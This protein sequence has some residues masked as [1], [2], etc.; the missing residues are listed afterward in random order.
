M[1]MALD[2]VSLAEISDRL[3]LS[4]VSWDAY[5]ALLDDVEKSG[6]HYRLTYD[7]GQLEIALPTEIHAIVTRFIRAILEA[8]LEEKN[9]DFVPLGDTT[10]KRRSLERGLEAD[11]C[12]YIQNAPRIG[13]RT[14]LD[15]D[16]DPPPD[17]AIEI[18]ATHPLLP[19]LPVY[20][21]LGVPEIWH[22]K[23]TGAI[24]ILHRRGATYE[25]A[26]A[27]LAVPFFTTERLQR[28]VEVRLELGHLP[29][30]RQFRASI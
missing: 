15:L 1:V 14:K 22:I 19:K 7:S 11:E 30:L 28:F 18:E 13:I 17:L 4:G 21:S 8:Y 23:T 6:R 3:L 5:E 27:S 24:E 26:A 20:V 12:Y 2:N 10:W 16:R 29:A 9:I 25:P